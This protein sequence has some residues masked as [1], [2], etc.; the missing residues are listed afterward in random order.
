MSLRLIQRFGRSLTI[1]RKVPGSY[2]NGLFVPGAEAQ[3]TIIGSVQ[4]VTGDELKL[5][6][7]GNQDR[8]KR[9]IY[10]T[11]ELKIQKAGV[12]SQVQESDKISLDGK[13]FQVI[14]V[15]SHL[16]SGKMTIQYY[17]AIVEA[18]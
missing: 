17:K 13:E 18:L 15:E 10:T 7:E 1:K 8:E 6:P 11:S 5:L 14:L 9:K 3:V 12:G 16:Y 4:P 2:V